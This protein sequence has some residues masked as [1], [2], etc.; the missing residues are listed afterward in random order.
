MTFFF[1]VGSDIEAK[2]IVDLRW[3]ERSVSEVK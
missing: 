3:K 1:S 2:G